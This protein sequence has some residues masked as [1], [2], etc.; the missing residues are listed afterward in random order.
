[1]NY[2]IFKGVDGR[3]LTENEIN[4]LYNDATAQVL[5]E[6]YMFKT[7]EKKIKRG[8]SRSE[9]GCALSHIKVYKDIIENNYNRVLILED[10]ALINSGSIQYLKKIVTEIPNQADLVYW[11]YRWYDMESSKSR[12]FR[13]VVR[14]PLFKLFGNLFKIKNPNNDRFP[15]KYKKHIWHSGYHSGT[16]AYSINLETAK[17]LL[18]ANTPI[19]MCADQL[20]QQLK[21]ESKLNCFVTIPVVFKED[22]SMVSTIVNN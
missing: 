13:Q 17:I 8:L 14:T 2:S 15:R 16:H 9:I 1:L 5:F 6:K 3:E 21:E 7:Y 18:N 12:L 20:F 11:G 19:T 4:S 10:D 22:Q